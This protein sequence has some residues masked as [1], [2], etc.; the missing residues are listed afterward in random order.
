[1]KN[2]SIVIYILFSFTFLIYLLL[3]NPVFPQSLPDAIQSNEPADMETPLR[4]GYFTNL[5]RDEVLKFYQDQFQKSSLMGLPLPTYRLNYPP[6][7]AQTIIRD[8]AR[9]SFLEEI[10]HPFRESIFINGFEPSKPQDVIVVEGKSWR[11]KII[12]RFVP[13]P[14]YIRLVIGVMVIILIPIIYGQLRSIFS[15]HD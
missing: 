2:I 1:M 7:E 14:I 4:R 3:P 11:Q 5:N 13:S 6:E 9:S 10:V 12:I 15:N 8:Q